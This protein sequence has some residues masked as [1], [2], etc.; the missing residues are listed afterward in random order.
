VFRWSHSIYWNRR[1]GMFKKIRR[2]RVCFWFW[3]HFYTTVLLL[4]T[5]HTYCSLTFSLILVLFFPFLHTQHQCTSPTWCTTT[6]A[7]FRRWPHKS[8]ALSLLRLLCFSS[9]LLFVKVTKNVISIEVK[10][11]I[12]IERRTKRRSEKVNNS[13]SKRTIHVRHS[14]W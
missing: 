5:P 12:S 3:A 9:L 11:V 7:G 14:C 4:Y 10:N 6:D 8:S 2:M 13:K 1:E